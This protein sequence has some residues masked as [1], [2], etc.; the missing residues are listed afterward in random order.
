MF[1]APFSV[2]QVTVPNKHSKESTFFFMEG[3][4]AE[5]EDRVGGRSKSKAKG[6]TLQE[7]VYSQ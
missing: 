1:E 3:Q 2:L 6:R 7:L 5:K 4:A